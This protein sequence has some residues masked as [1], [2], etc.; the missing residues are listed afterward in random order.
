MI[1]SP[2]RLSAGPLANGVPATPEPIGRRVMAALAKFNVLEYSGRAGGGYPHFGM[3]GDPAETWMGWTA[4]PQSFQGQAQLGKTT[5]VS[6]QTYPALPADNPPAAIVQW[7]PDW[8]AGLDG[9]S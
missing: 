5:G 4:T 7:L 6:V 9:G 3:K 8:T 1:R 2:S